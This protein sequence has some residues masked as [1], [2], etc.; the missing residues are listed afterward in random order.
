MTFKSH[1]GLDLFSTAWEVPEPKAHVAIMHG[2]GEHI[3]R[4]A[5][6]ASALNAAG[7]G[8]IG[9]DHRNHGQSP[10]Q[11]GYI[12]RFSWLVEDAA[13]FLQHA[14]KKSGALPLFVLGHSMGGLTLARFLECH[15][16]FEA[17]GVVF[18]SPF[19]QIGDDVSPA[20]IAIGNVLSVI[21]PKLPVVD[22]EPEKISSIPE[23]VAR[24]MNDPLVFHGRIVARTGSELNGAV[25]LAR[26]EAGKIN[27]PTLI[28]HGTDD[29]LAPIGGGEYLFEHISSADKIFKKYDG[30]YHELFNDKDR[31]QVAA[32]LVDW[33]NERI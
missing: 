9:Y 19:V 11:R 18:S 14:Q 31:E 8:V 4:Y 1:D 33:L 25:K 13:C 29:R 17:K 15:P 5:Q 16:G 10:G 2:Y 23:E 6:L 20:L 32:D 12:E 28:L 22:L 3:G 30:G 24:Y 27:L 21:L 26:A 7:F